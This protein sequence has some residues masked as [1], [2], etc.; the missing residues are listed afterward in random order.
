MQN[1]YIDEFII[2]MKDPNNKKNLQ[3]ITQVSKAFGQKPSKMIAPD[4][5]DPKA[6]SKLDT[7]ISNLPID[8]QFSKFEK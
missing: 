7:F 5:T 2:M 6:K 8:S 3:L 4:L 1:N